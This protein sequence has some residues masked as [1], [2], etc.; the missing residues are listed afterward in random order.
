M[1]PDAN[2]MR[3]AIELAESNFR[4]GGYA[5]GALVVRDSE[6]IAEATN[7]AVQSNDPT[8]HAEVEAIRLACRVGGTR[9]LEGCYLY[10]TYEPCP[11]CA[12]AAIWAKMSGIIYGATNEDST[13]SHR[14]RVRIAA[15]DVVAKGEPRLELH[16]GF[17]REECNKL[18][19]LNRET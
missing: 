12:S 17:M 7:Q 18:L 2:R 3:R 5:V 4:L 19:Q 13:Q 1:I 11:M 16:E 6:I 10:S 15:K 14:W 9:Y 8:A